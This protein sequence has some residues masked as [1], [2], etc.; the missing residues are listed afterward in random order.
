MAA[1]KWLLDSGPLVALL[2]GRDTHHARCASIFETIEGIPI[3]SEAVLTEAM[4]LLGRRPEGAQACLDFFR[5][6]G[7]LLVPLTSRLLGR[8]AALMESYRTLPMDFAD[9]TLVALAE[10]FSI[11]RVLTLDRR[12]FSVYRRHGRRAFTIVP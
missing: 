1:V 4:H 10:E 3:T 8:C 12:D 11:P 2:S 9:A 5:R 7:A 6:G